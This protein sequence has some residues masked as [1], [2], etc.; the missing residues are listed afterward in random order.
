M[1]KNIKKLFLLTITASTLL[2]CGKENNNTSSS[3]GEINKVSL[4]AAIKNTE[5]NYIVEFNS[6]YGYSYNWAIYS[7]DLYYYAPMFGGYIQLDED[8]DFYHSYDFITNSDSIYEGIINVHGRIAYTSERSY[9]YSQNLMDIIKN[10]LIDFERSIEENVYFCRV[11]DLAYELKNYFQSHSFSYCNYFELV[12]GDDGRLSK[13]IPYEVSSESGKT[14]I[15]DIS[16]EKFD[17]SN[18]NP[19]VSWSNEGR[20]IDLRLIDL[21]YGGMINDNDYKLLYED[22]VCSVEGTV[23]SFDY[24]NSFYITV[25]DSNTGN[26]GMQVTLNGSQELPK[27]NQKIKVTGKVIQSNLVAKIEDATYE[28]LGNSSYYAYF[29]EERIADT[30]GGGYYAA[31]IFS[32]TPIYADSVYSTYAYIESLPTSEIK[33]NIST[34]IPLVCPEMVLDDGS[35]FQMKLILPSKMPLLEK[36]K[37]IDDLKQYGVYDK[38]NNTALELS[39]DKMILRFVFSYLKGYSLQLE[40]G[41]ESSISKHLTPTEK[42]SKR[43]ELNNFP[44]PNVE[45]YSCF[46]FGSSTGLYIE[47]NYGLDDYKTQGIYYNVSSLNSDLYEAQIHNM[48][49]IGFE[50][51]KEIKD[52]TG[53]RHIIY[54]YNDFYADILLSSALFEE[55]YNFSMWLYKGEFVHKITAQEELVN[56]ISYFDIDDFVQPDCIQDADVTFWRLPGYGGQQ[57][58]NGNLLHCITLDSNEECFQQ[59]KDGYKNNGFK[60]LRTEDNK[61]YVYKTRGS[62]HYLYYK[63]IEGTNEK[64][65]VDMV[66]YS[67]TDYTFADHSYFTYRYEVLVYKGEEPL[68]TVY[69]E[70]LDNFT[71]YM[72]NQYGDTPFK[73]ELPDETKIEEWPDAGVE[74]NYAYIT[75]GYFFGYNVF[76]YSSKLNEVYNSIVLSLEKQGYSLSF[77]TT[78]G[79]V[80]YVKKTGDELMSYAY[81]FVMKTSSYIRIID[82]AGGVD[83]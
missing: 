16:F 62:N 34:T 17:L 64:V 49:A 53:S 52:A 39:L 38:D 66:M 82:S 42:V 74:T 40:Y 2:G 25:E 27:I 1:N 24:N 73:I 56:S 29:D 30:Y 44:F 70:N 79:N 26:V 45:S 61:L 57:F 5:D 9:L 31:N 6:A 63:D 33:E 3:T 35:F 15:A 7:P 69:S 36:Q 14:A 11:K 60:S 77:T 68:S 22:E 32:Q 43:L 21:K 19:Y 81:I 46:S 58:T 67:T 55:A 71:S 23:A 65:F 80:C 78:K 50:F 47:T 72:S 4:E 59:L 8:K 51:Y 12:V 54:K 13:L 41:S 48:E 37:I 83:F 28:L 20:K 76:L 10:Y 18:Y 75:Y